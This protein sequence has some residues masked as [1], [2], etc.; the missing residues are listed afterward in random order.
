MRRENSEQNILRGGMPLM[1]QQQSDEGQGTDEFLLQEYEHFLAGKA[2]GTIDA[3]VRTT[4]HLMA[5]VAQ[6]PGNGGHFHP[7]QLRKTAVEVY[8]ASL[9][10]QGFSLNHRARVKSTISSFARWLMEEKGLLQRNPTRGVDL[11]SQHMLAPRQL[12]EDQRYILRSLVEQEEDRR[13]AAIFALGYWAGCRVSDVSWLQMAH[14]HVG[15][16]AGWL[17]VGYKGGKWRDIDLMNEARKPLYEYLKASGDADRTYV[18]LSQRN[19]R[20]TEEGIHHWFRTLMA[21]A[22]KGQWELIHNLTF[23][24][25][26]HDFAHRAREAGWSLEE[27]AYYLGHVTK[28]GKPAI[29]TTVRYTQ[30]S[31]EQVKEKLKHVRG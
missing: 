10:Q 19:E 6:R 8:L 15:P 27:V 22:T 12:S 5:W 28:K 31:R 23:H 1:R 16:K 4:R 24:D 26:R 2:E 3:Y 20:L 25:L 14:T 7:R 21:G 13:G 9:E 18:F 30:V 29:Q 17:H 11:L